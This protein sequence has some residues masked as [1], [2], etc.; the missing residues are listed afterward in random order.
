[1]GEP[2]TKNTTLRVTKL[3]PQLTTPTEMRDSTGKGNG[4]ARPRLLSLG[5]GG[6]LLLSGGASLPKIRLA[7]SWVSSDGFGRHWDQVYSLGY[8][9]LAGAFDG[10]AIPW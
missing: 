2:P 9:Q 7:F 8:T 4:C 1:M 6:P 3:G 5:S 10:F